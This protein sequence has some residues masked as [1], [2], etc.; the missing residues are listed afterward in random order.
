MKLIKESW[1]EFKNQSTNLYKIIDS[2]TGYEVH[3]SDFGATLVRVKVPDKDGKIDDINFGQNSPEEYIKEGGYLGAVVG[4][5]AN[6]IENAEFELDDK[7]YSLF[8]NNANKHS[9][10][11][12]K[13]GFNVNWWFTIRWLFIIA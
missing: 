12:G 5:I 10:H 1:V 7:K 3:I 11:G 9:L 8:V 2:N 4:R 6:R 13:E